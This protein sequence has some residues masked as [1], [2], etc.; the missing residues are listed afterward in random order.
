MWRTTKV[1]FLCLMISS[2]SFGQKGTHTPYSILGVGEL[3]MNDYAAF[4]SMGGVSLANT[5]STM[6]N[7]ANPATYSYIGRLRPILQIGLNGRFSKFETETSSTNQRFFGLN[8]FQL[9]VPIKKRWGTAIGIKPYSFTG[10]KI[11][12]YTVVDGDSTELY[13]S[14]G[15]GGINKFYFG[16]A[17]QPLKISY[18]RKRPRKIRD[19]LGVHIDSFNLSRSH[20][21]SIGANA[22]YIFGTSERT[23]TYQFA[24]FISE[25][26][27]RVDNGLRL[28]GLLFDFGLGYQFRWGSSNSDGRMKKRYS[29]SLGATY[30][31]A[32]EVRAF[33]DILAY[34]YQNFGSIFNGSENIQDTIEYITDNKGSLSIPES[35]KVGF[36]FRIGPTSELRSSQLRIGVD[37]RYQ[38]WSEYSENFGTSFD[39]QLKDRLQLGLGLE[40]TPITSFSDPRSSILS[41]AHYRLGFTYAMTELQFE[42]SPNIYTGLTSYGMS[43]GLGF[44]I[45]MIKNSNTNINFGANLGNLGTT[46]NGLI[47]EK[48]IGLFVG[49]SITPGNGDLWFLKRKYD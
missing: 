6:V 48:Y 40:W 12:N 20:I 21:L 35:Y 38:K 13:T 30:S 1:L 14:E 23:R 9:G 44:P 33:Q 19:S 43:F 36:E 47:R 27:A 42:T 41:K 4:L 2:A 24:K 18:S 45:T 25:Y 46:E 11:S 28:S 15:S 22:N 5:D 17:Y 7:P 10:Y 26:N 32:L 39:N 16:L 34:S 31:P 49:L 8:Q 37:A 3:K 29:L